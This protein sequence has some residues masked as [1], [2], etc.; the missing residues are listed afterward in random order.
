MRLV[1]SLM[2]PKMAPCVGIQM[3]AKLQTLMADKALLGEKNAGQLFAKKNGFA[4]NDIA[5]RVETL[6]NADIHNI[7]KS[8]AFADKDDEEVL[9]PVKCELLVKQAC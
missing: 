7:T 1:G 5:A 9:R 8:A 4:T 2:D 3:N 6:P